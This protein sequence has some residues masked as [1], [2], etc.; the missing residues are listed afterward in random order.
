[1]RK[2][3]LPLALI[4]MVSFVALA[5]AVASPAGKEADEKKAEAKKPSDR[6]V[7][8]YF[9]RTQRCPTCQKMGAYSEEAVAKGFEKQLKEGSVEFHY[10]DF[11]DEKNAAITKAYKIGGPTLLAV[12]IVKDK[13]V[14]GENLKE[15][16]TKV[17]DH[18][19]FLKYVR[20]TV[21]A[22]EKRKVPEKRAE[23]KAG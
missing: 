5:S 9:H 7:V 17:R 2:M 15:I 3:T 21:V 6:I 23:Q 13:P 22:L 14:D 11:Q 18:E 8:M 20:D 12:K 4:A 1:M 19:A 10:I 16:W